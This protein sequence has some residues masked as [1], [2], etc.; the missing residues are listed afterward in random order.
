MANTGSQRGRQTGLHARHYFLL[1]KERQ[2]QPQGEV[3]T[4]IIQTN[5][6]NMLKEIIVV[7]SEGHTNHVS[8]MCEQTAGV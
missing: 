6:S 5:K 1:R 4:F 2:S 3:S 7:C 8:E